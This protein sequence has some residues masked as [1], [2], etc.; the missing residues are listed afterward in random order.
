MVRNRTF[1]HRLFL[2]I[3][4]GIFLLQSGCAAVIV[5]SAVAGGAAGYA[6]YKGNVRRVV[7]GDLEKTWQATERSLAELNISPLTRQKNGVHGSM[8]CLTPHDDNIVISL[9][10]LPPGKKVKGMQANQPM[11]QI[12]IRVNTFGDQSFSN[13]ILD[14]VELYLANPNAAVAPVPVQ[15]GPLNGQQGQNNPALSLPAPPNMP[16]QSVEPPQI[17]IGKGGN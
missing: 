7:P 17:K 4:S 15:I 9:E 8:R 2:A 12:D 1:P 14:K 13:L 10:Q 3:L 11:T 16:P 5:G 6:Y